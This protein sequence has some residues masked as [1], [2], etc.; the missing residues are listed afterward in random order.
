[1]NKR[2]LYIQTI[3]TDQTE[4]QADRVLQLWQLTDRKVK[5]EPSHFLK[6]L[7]ASPQTAYL[8][9]PRTQANSLHNQYTSILAN[10]FSNFE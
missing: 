7:L 5:T 6:L 3:S 10:A 4:F 8:V 2:I 9:L 1:M